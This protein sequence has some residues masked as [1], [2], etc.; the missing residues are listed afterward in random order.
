LQINPVIP[1]GWQGFK[2]Q[3]RFRGATYHITV[4]R[5]GPGNDVSIRVDGQ[6]IEGDIIP[7]SQKPDVMVDVTLV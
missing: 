5:K 2:V 6:P 3:R 7:P 4:T 1:A